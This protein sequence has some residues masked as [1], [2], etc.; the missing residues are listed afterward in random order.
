MIGTNNLYTCLD[1]YETILKGIK[2]HCSKSKVMLMSITPRW[3]EEFMGKI[4]E[5]NQEI[6]KYAGIYGYF[7][8]NAFTS[9]TVNNEN[10]VANDIYFVD[11]LHP[12]VEGYEVI[13]N[14]IKP[15]IIEWLK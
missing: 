8:V 7:Y 13:T 11:G 1:N 2:E 6:Q 5:I 4:C 10:L 9:L 15:T 12:N 14:L 3:G